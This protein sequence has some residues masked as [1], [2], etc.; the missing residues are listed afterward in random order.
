M[1]SSSP[2]MRLI[3]KLS[4]FTG[5]RQANPTPTRRI[6]FLLPMG[7]DRPSGRRYFNIAR[8]LVRLGFHVRLLA[9]HPDFA[10]CPQRRFVVDGVEVWYVGQMHARK[11]GSIPLSFSPFQLLLVVVQ[12]TLGMIWGV[13]HSPATWYHLGKPQPING[14]AALLA[15]SLW[16]RQP[17]FVDCDDDEATANRFT[18]RWQQAVFAFWQWL[19][20]RLAIGVTV[21]TQYLAAQM[22]QPGRPCVI[23]PNGVAADFRAPPLHIRAALTSALGLQHG[24]VIAYAGTLALHNH[25]VDLLLQAFD[26]I[27]AQHTTAR[28]LIIGGGEDLPLIRSYI[29]RQP[30]RG[31]VILTGHLPH[32]TVRGLLALADLSVDPVYD[33]SVARARC[34]LKIVESLAL[35]VPVITGDVG[36]RAEMLGYGAAGMLVPPGNAA[37][38]AAAIHELL[39]NPQR[40]KAM[41]AAALVQASR[42]DWERLA[43]R[44]ATIYDRANHQCPRQPTDR[45]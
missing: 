39:I 43:A 12:S 18:A 15:I 38:L 31:R 40:R 37:A 14:M 35:G 1:E 28:L 36:D 5:R 32:A 4:I 41:A 23:V 45:E 3:N 25:P 34:P 44:W 30:W 24:P 29:E 16:R 21:N 8:G 27:A 6:V 33:D 20:P 26:Q 17:F 13:L 11:I 42:Y 19:L 7:I 2:V 10:T 22:A 9:L